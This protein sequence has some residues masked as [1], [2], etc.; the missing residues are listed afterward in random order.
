[1]DRA[2]HYSQ[3]MEKGSPEKF[4]RDLNL[5]ALVSVVGGETPVLV[6][7]NRHRDIENAAEFCDKQKL[8]MILTGGSEAWR[9]KDILRFRSIPVILR[10]TQSL[11]D[12]ED[13]PYESPTAIRVNCT[14][15]ASRSPSPASMRRSPDASLTRRPTPCPTD[16][17]TTRRCAPS[18]STAQILGLADQ[19][20]SI[21]RARLLILLSPAATR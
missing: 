5:E 1:M 6:V 4:D 21:E 20:G 8:K 14:L 11:P 12:E 2:R 17:R 9:V 13:T 16:C 15:P 3:A 10:P 18:R 19:L 7:A